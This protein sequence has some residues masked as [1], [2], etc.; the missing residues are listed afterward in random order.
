MQEFLI[1]QQR[2]SDVFDLDQAMPPAEGTALRADNPSHALAQLHRLLGHVEPDFGGGR[3]ALLVCPGCLEAE[4]G[5]LS[6]EVRRTEDTVVWADA[7]WQDATGESDA[8]RPVSGPRTITFSRAQYES[9]LAQALS[10]WRGITRLSTGDM[11]A[12]ELISYPVLAVDQEGAVHC[13]DDRDALE[14]MAEMF[15]HGEFTLV[16]DS[17]GFEYSYAEGDLPYIE[18]LSSG[19]ATAADLTQMVEERV[20]Y[21][22]SRGKLRHAPSSQATNGAP[23]NSDFSEAFRLVRKYNLD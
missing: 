14:G 18:L 6:V 10:R 11:P 8:V 3:V 12:P 21:L 19:L 7:G 1:D 13:F 9:A 23:I 4:C 20:N 2:L 17:R 5:E 16:V 22:Q 15:L